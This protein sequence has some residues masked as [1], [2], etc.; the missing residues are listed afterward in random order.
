VKA[1]VASV[2]AADAEVATI[3]DRAET[4]EAASRLDD[5]AEPAS[6]AAA[7]R[8]G[9]VPA[10]TVVG[11]IVFDVPEETTSTGVAVTATG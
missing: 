11:A 7:S 3:D 5:P 2:V 9:T 8:T 6:P 10:A 1:A 4:S